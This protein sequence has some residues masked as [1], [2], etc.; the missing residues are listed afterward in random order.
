M[1]KH[2]FEVKTTDLLTAGENL[3]KMF[4]QVEREIK[5][6]EIGYSAFYG[7]QRADS[8]EKKKRS[9]KK[10]LRSNQLQKAS[11]EEKTKVAESNYDLTYGGVAK[12][13]RIQTA[14]ESVIQ[15]KITSSSLEYPVRNSIAPVHHSRPIV[16]WRNTRLSCPVDASLSALWIPYLRLGLVRRGATANPSVDL[17]Y[18]RFMQCIR[19]NARLTVKTEAMLTREK[20][21]LIRTVWKKEKHETLFGDVID[22]LKLLSP[23][24]CNGLVLN[25]Q[26]SGVITDICQS[27]TK[28]STPKVSTP[29][30]YADFVYYIENNP[31]EQSPNLLLYHTPFTKDRLARKFPYRLYHHEVSQVLEYTLQ[32]VILYNGSH[33]KTLMLVAD[34]SVDRSLVSLKY[35]ND[36]R[37]TYLRNGIW[38]HDPLETTYDGRD[39]SAAF[40]SVLNHTQLSA[41]LKLSKPQ[42]I[43]IDQATGGRHFGADPKYKPIVWVYMKSDAFVSRKQTKSEMNDIA[44][45]RD[46]SNLC[47]LNLKM[48]RLEKSL[49]FHSLSD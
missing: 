33:F 14:K 36:L 35:P 17:F 13:Q 42:N 22:S 19:T 11:K 8:K 40:T 4:L 16:S 30:V 9:A 48:T 44:V 39:A 32:S 27:E 46:L 5:L 1:L 23:L 7:I 25:V 37:S 45:A 21:A 38:E 24:I 31:L 20:D 28:S 47:L 49:A 29:S 2:D 43:V 34:Q 41:N 3:K 15:T 12:K 18:S 10:A 6:K 26:L